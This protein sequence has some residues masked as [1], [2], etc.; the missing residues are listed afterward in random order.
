MPI[1]PSIPLSGT[2]V[3]APNLGGI[4]QQYQALQTKRQADAAT[5]ALQA[6]KL[7]QEQ[8]AQAD[9]ATYNQILMKH[10][11]PEGNVDLDGVTKDLIGAGMGDRVPALTGQWTDAAKKQGEVVAQGF[12]LLQKRV[13]MAAGL[14]QSIIDSPDPERAFQ[15][16]KPS[17]VNMVGEQAAALLGD[18][19]D[20]T[21]FKNTVGMA[22]DSARDLA[23]HT[24][25]INETN[26]TLDRIQKA[27]DSQQTW[28]KESPGIVTSTQDLISKGLSLA[29]SQGEW[30]SAWQTA[31]NYTLG[32]PQAEREMALAPFAPL[33][34]FTPANQEI[35]RKGGMT[36]EQLSQEA[37]QKQT[38]QDV[39]D[40]QNITDQGIISLT[41]EAKDMYA[42]QLAHTGK[43]PTAILGG[44]R[45]TKVASTYAEIGNLAA[46]K[47]KGLNLPEQ[48]A[49]YAGAKS[50]LADLEKQQANISAYINVGLKNLKTY[51]DNAAKM[52]DSGSPLLNTPIRMLSDKLLGSTDMAAA[53]AARNEVIPEVAKIARGYGNTMT[54]ED[55][56]ATDAILDPSAT[57]PQIMAA[58]KVIVQGAYNR[59]DGIN[60]AMKLPLAIINRPPAIRYSS[61]PDG[62]LVSQD[63]Q[64]T[65][66][67]SAAP[68]T[69]T[70]TNG[71]LVLHF[72]TADAQQKYLQ[73][74]PTA[75]AGG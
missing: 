47:Y 35:A 40:K 33:T 65:S 24:A 1:D 46:D 66:A 51:V 58:A 52:P 34:E 20:P 56:K 59:Q 15:A 29:R 38:R 4:L 25:L 23:A 19:Y 50:T 64:G 36:Q 10:G 60:E 73:T 22:S 13:N 9:T 74:H 31:Q 45:N 17:L 41:P 43:M 57:Y 37:I 8:K 14:A 48:Q 53:T 21:V 67:P 75:K 27:R 2:P 39:E 26:A 54:V 68:A 71:G 11:T 44:S 61:A 55:R 5:Q 12:D 6:Q 49:A 63:T 7:E 18:H 72:P 62:S 3:Q 69:F 28:A 70:V 42:D 30:D 32:L 16:A